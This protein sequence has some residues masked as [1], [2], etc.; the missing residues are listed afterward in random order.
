VAASASLEKSFQQI[1]L[2]VVP[3]EFE[4]LRGNFLQGL[5]GKLRINEISDVVVKWWSHF[6]LDHFLD[7][8]AGVIRAI[9]QGTPSS[10]KVTDRLES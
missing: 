9:N 10:I 8:S 5:S 3:R 2:R 7:W 1:F 4:K 6:S